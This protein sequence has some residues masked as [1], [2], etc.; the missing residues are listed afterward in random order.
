[1]QLDDERCWIVLAEWNEFVWPGPDLGRS[2]P[3][4][5][6]IY[7]RLPPR[8]FEKIRRRFITTVRAGKAAAV[9]RTNV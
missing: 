3:G 2:A 4:D 7:E 8:L 9:R 6:L 5:M 1:M